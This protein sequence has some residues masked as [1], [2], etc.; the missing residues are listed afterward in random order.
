MI[1]VRKVNNEK[2]RLT[3]IAWQAG[4]VQK[5]LWLNYTSSEQRIQATLREGKTLR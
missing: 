4:H 5:M 3:W 1:L 2:D